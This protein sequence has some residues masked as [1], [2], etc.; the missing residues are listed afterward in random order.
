MLARGAIACLSALAACSPSTRDCVEGSQ[1]WDTEASDV[2]CV[3]GDL[4]VE[5]RSAKEV[6]I[7]AEIEDIEGSLVI[8]D[9]PALDELPEW[10]VLSHIGG[11]L[12]LSEN[13]ALAV[14]H[15][16]PALERIDG[17]LYVAE[18]P[19]LS[20]LALGNTLVSVGSIF[21]AL[22]PELVEFAAPAALAQVEGDLNV[23]ANNGLEVLEFPSL[24]GVAGSL[25]IEDNVA[26]VSAT[27]T[28]LRTVGGDLS[29][30][31]DLSLETLDGFQALERV[32]GQVTISHNDT[33][34]TV[35]LA[36]SIDTP[37][38][39]IMNNA[40]LT[41]ISGS[42]PA[43][44]GVHTSVNIQKNP[45]LR[46]IDDFSGVEV[47]AGLTIEENVALIEFAG[48]RSLVRV[49]PYD[50]SVVR[51][52]ALAGPADLLP[53]LAGV[54]ELRVFG[55]KSL[56]P[57]V[58]QGLLDHVTVEGDTRVGDNQG[59][60]TALDPCPWA[61]DGLCDAISP[62]GGIYTELCAI[63]PEDCL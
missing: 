3:R 46:S 34:K 7:L 28:T 51:N 58:V 39:L 44:I 1:V 50:L 38:L 33:L 25:Y 35:S 30:S 57:S 45:A 31:G 4:I 60:E 41:R 10:P 18:N 49:G 47:L 24:S 53:V 52:A 59:E 20:Q 26:L 48:L 40:A 13:A 36:A 6:A 37:S 12:S 29:I 43:R 27:F 63:D 2:V 22:N 62:S 55:N 54:S 15:G 16:F 14:V 8:H 17:R 61:G 5:G 23:S 42:A 21:L 11:A 32:T 56:P 9:N 19:K